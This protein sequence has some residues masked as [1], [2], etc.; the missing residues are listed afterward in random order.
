MKPSLYEVLN[1]AFDAE[2][3]QIKNA[4]QTKI[5]HIK[6]AVQ[7]KDFM[8]LGINNDATP[9]DFNEAAKQ[10]IKKIKEAYIILSN[11]K[12]R[13]SYD[14]KLREA[15]PEIFKRPELE[16]K[17]E[18][19]ETASDDMDSS[20]SSKVAL[21]SLNDHTQRNQILTGLALLLLV[22]GFYIYQLMYP[23]ALDIE[24]DNEYIVPTLARGVWEGYQ[25]SVLSNIITLEVSPDGQRVASGT[26]LLNNVQ[27]RDIATGEILQEL[28]GANQIQVVKYHPTKPILAVGTLYNSIH[29]WDFEEDELQSLDHTHDGNISK[30][31]GIYD[32]AFNSDGSL[33][34]SVSWDGSIMMWDVENQVAKWTVYA[35]KD[36]ISAHGDSVQ[37]V[38]FSPDDSKIA[39]ASLDNTVRIWNA[40]TGEQLQILLGHTD[41]VLSLAFSPDGRWL[42]S[43]GADHFIYI[44]DM[45][46]FE[47]HKII[48]G[49][50]DNVADLVFMQNSNVL[51][52]GSADKMVRYWEISS[53]GHVQ[54]LEGHTGF[55]YA[56]ALSP[57]E[58]TLLT[59]GGDDV[60]RVWKTDE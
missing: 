43:G 57:D 35:N 52:S 10:R 13:D 23:S 11:S 28:E 22:V 2:P 26:T 30:Y 41:W 50:D 7:G 14:K 18:V 20:T 33:F 46:T 24:P 9:E 44:W 29:L 47:R 38:A 6:E 40:E 42:A 45:S 58:K 4:A 21:P 32:I 34:A 12:T 25:K 27:I 19:V 48:R 56:V 1:I 49:H 31:S 59:G 15:H 3:D 51:I 36:K 8:F 16:Q 39:T 54:T 5:S 17:P 55:V 60:V 37:S 53:G